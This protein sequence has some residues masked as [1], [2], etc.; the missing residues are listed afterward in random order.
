[1]IHAILHPEY[2]EVSSVHDEKSCY[3]CDQE[4]YNSEWQRI[5]GCGPTVASNIIY[6]LSRTKPHACGLDV[7]NDKTGCVAL[8]EKVWSYV[9]PTEE[10]VDTTKKFYDSLSAYFNAADIPIL[11]EMCDIPEKM[12]DR[13]ALKEVLDFL[14]RA[15]EK[16]A[17][18]A[19][20]NLCNGEEPN[21]EAWHWV[22]IISLRHHENIDQI[23]A[24]ILDEGQFKKIDLALWYN[25][26]VF[27]GGFVYFGNTR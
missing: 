19:F 17:P 6:Y 15:L 26:S 7:R 5:S 20:L 12:A 21:L 8:M 25:T 16:D 9:T 2:F 3:G 13:P 23:H 24:I 22:T 27:G 11:A 4:W 1:M 18:V 14:I 10:G